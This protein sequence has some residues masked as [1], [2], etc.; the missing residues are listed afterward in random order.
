MKQIS[1]RTIK[2]RSQG[3]FKDKR[4]KFLSFVFPVT[5]EDQ[6]KEILDDLHSE[7]HDARHHC[8]AWRIG[9]D[10][11]L[12]RANDDGEP[13]G[14]AG[15]PVLGQILKY[16]LTNILIVV[17]RYFGGTLLGTGG[18]ITAYR[19][20]A[21]NALEQSEIITQSVEELLEV[22]F[23]YSDMNNVMKILKEEQAEQVEQYIS[24]DC[25]I[26]VSIPLEKS[27]RV[28]DRLEGIEQVSVN[29]LSINY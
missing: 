28:K 13:S 18:L 8:Y 27:E 2:N 4:S 10:K 12:F 23:P 17:V 26:R 29:K 21:A 16:D 20:A 9:A 15:R 3:L 19:S 7:Y 22:R 25:I 1:Y 5:T 24:M 14:T 11:K 6:I